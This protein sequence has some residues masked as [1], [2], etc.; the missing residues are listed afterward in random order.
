MGM[1]TAG[2]TVA[3]TGMNARADNPGPGLAV[4]RCLRESP[5][6]EGRIVGLGYDVL[7]PGL[8]LPDMCDSGF[9]LPYP[10]AGEQALLERLEALHESEG[11]DILIPCLD[12]ELPSFSRLQPQLEAMGI[13][14]VMATAEQL[15][16]RSKDRLQEFAEAAGVNVPQT[17]NITQAGFF[18]RCHE[19]GW[20]YPLVVKGMFYDAGIAWNADQAAGIFRRIAAEWGLP[21][22]VQ[23]FVEGEEVNLTAIGDGQGKLIAPVMMR[24]RAITDK[25]K[26]WAGVTVEDHHLLE[27]SEKL[28]KQLNW[29]GPLEVEMM[30]DHEGR[31]HLIEINPRFPAWVYLTHAVG[32]NLPA[33][34][35]AIAQGEPL[36]DIPESRPGT[37][38]IR[39]AQEAIVDLA[40]FESMTLAGSQA[41]ITI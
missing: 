19:E 36:P 4:A 20:R 30:C 28:A 9:L 24:K 27:A 18:Y 22:L 40:A 1:G 38:F 10:S 41:G 35:L 39:Y 37:T 5:N 31:Y 21:V 3:I 12:A 7:D 32:R 11:I 8:Y 29:Y 33:I 14:L 16:V 23:R 2:S 25:G 13:T 6:F 34:L 26:A 15:M 17:K